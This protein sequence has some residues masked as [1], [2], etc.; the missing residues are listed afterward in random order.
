MED[1][2]AHGAASCAEIVALI[3]QSDAIQLQ[4]RLT[5]DLNVLSQS[6][7]TCMYVFLCMSRV[8]H[9]GTLYNAGTREFL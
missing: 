3:L 9:Y 1:D 6:Y 4:C 7:S 8:L 2:H 5:C